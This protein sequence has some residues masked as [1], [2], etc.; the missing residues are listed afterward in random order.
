[1]A[2]DNY[3]SECWRCCLGTTHPLMPFVWFMLFVAVPA[4]AL[5]LLH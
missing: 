3:F 1:M 4:L 2:E 5:W